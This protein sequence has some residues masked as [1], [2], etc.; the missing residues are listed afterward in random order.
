MAHLG[1]IVGYEIH[2]H[3]RAGKYTTPIHD[4]NTVSRYVYQYEKNN[5]SKYKTL[6]DLPFLE[7]Q[8]QF[9]GDYAELYFDAR[10][11]K[12]QNPSENKTKL[13]QMAEIMK[14][15]GYEET[16]AVKWILNEMK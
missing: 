15:S 11:G 5:L 2:Y 3:P 13:K 4:G 1:N 7:S 6:S 16:G 10:F 8:A 14:N 9:V 12:L